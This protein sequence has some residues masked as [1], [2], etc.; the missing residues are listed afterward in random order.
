LL[1][2]ALR[3]HAGQDYGDV[4]HSGY[5]SPKNAALS[6]GRVF[7]LFYRTIQNMQAFQGHA[8]T[9]PPHQS[10]LKEEIFLT[11]RLTFIAF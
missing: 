5:Y 2:W 10:E 3:P 7:Y 11:L 9:Q 1:P 6:G 8:E 4:I